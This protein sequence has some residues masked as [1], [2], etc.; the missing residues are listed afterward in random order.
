[1]TSSRFDPSSTSKTLNLFLLRFNERSGSENLVH[2]VKKKPNKN[3]NKNT[4][5]YTGYMIVKLKLK[6]I[7]RKRNTA[8]NPIT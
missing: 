8:S 3:K 4:V 6:E 1:M 5:N 7:R 2:K